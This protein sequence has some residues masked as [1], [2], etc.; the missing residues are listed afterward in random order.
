MS[1]E[2]LPPRPE[3]ESFDVSEP[4]QEPSATDGPERRVAERTFDGTS[5]LQRA[6][7]GL[8]TAGEW[9]AQA[10]ADERA[11]AER[12]EPTVSV[13]QDE[14]VDLE[15]SATPDAPAAAEDDPEPTPRELARQRKAE[16]REARRADKAARRE[17]RRSARQA[18]ETDAETDAKSDAEP[19]ASARE[20]EAESYDDLP[21]EIPV[22]DPGR[23]DDVDRDVERSGTAAPQVVDP[24]TNVRERRAAAKAARLEA[25]RS[26][27]QVPDVDLETTAPVSDRESESEGDG[28]PSGTASPSTTSPRLDSRARRATAKQARRAAALERRQ[29]RAEARSRRGVRRDETVDP[30]LVEQSDVVDEREPDEIDRELA[31]D[32]TTELAAVAA[33]AE[34]EEHVDADRLEAE[35]VEA[36]RLEAERL[37]A[38]Q[39]IAE[40][41]A[42]ERLA[43]QQA[44]A[45]RAEA[46]RIEA[47]RAAEAAT[48]ADTRAAEQ[49]QV[50]QQGSDE[51]EV[52]WEDVERR[53]S[54]AAVAVSARAAARER[55]ASD[56][57]RKIEAKAAARL[58]KDR[59]RRGSGDVDDVP[60][61]PDEAGSSTRTSPLTVVAAVV[62]AGGLILSVVLAVGAMLAALGT[63][64]GT[65]YSVVS[66]ICDAL[67]APLA[68]LVDFSG[69]N[70]EQK[71]ALVAWGLGSIVY[72]AIGLGA[73]S[74]LRS[75]TEDD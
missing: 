43:A 14:V 65:L 25:R 59:A 17:A 62:G 28:E 67:T 32:V 31:D 2:P 50:E 71:E 38:E 22:V 20:V 69:S 72:L 53:A 61:P 47:E 15:T 66:S 24:H 54:E 75:R 39:L 44:E 41:L 46:E 35:Q 12:R 30:P 19:D 73:Q 16:A 42:A 64:S 56:R 10:E 58:E 21:A 45:E 5:P 36:E 3:K 8:T 37:A 70:A 49:T 51:P 40:E 57:Q 48:L 23:D 52:D 33:T 27:Q 29:V 6:L 26:T 9:A 18:P 63:D 11:S 68:G 60:E 1:R 4:P 13:E 34:A 7:A 55:K 74:L